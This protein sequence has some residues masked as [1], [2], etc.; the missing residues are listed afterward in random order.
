[1]KVLQAY[2]FALDSTPR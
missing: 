1:M 2:H